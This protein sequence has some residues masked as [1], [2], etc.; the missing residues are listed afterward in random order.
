QFGSV[1]NIYKEIKKNG[2]KVKIKP[3][4]LKLLTEGKKDAEMS[5]M[6]ATIVCDVPLDFSIED[7]KLRA[8]DKQKVFELFKEL[9]FRSLLARLP[10]FKPDIKVEKNKIEEDEKQSVQTTLPQASQSKKDSKV[11]YKLVNSDSEFTGFIN[12]L[13][14][15]K[16]F[17]LDTESTSLDAIS[18]KLLGISFCWSDGWAY[19]LNI[20]DNRLWLKKLK[21]ILESS[22]VEKFGHNIKYDMTLLQQAGIKIMPVIFDSMV[23]SYLLNPGT[24][25]HSLDNLAFEVFGYQMQPITDLIGKGKKKI[26]MEAVP[27]DKASWYACEDAD[28]TYRLCQYLKPELEEKNILGLMEKI[29]MPLIPVLATLEQNGV[30]I[31]TGFLVA[32]SKQE[33]RRLDILE[34]KIYEH[35]KTEFNINS[36]LQLKEVLFE[37]LKI[38][39]EGISKIKTG[40][41]TAAAELEKLKNAHPIIPL[42]SDF[43]ELSKLRSTYLEALPRLVN[44]KTNRVHTSFNQTITA[45]G[46]LSSSNPNLQNIPIRTEEGRKIRQAFIA[47]KGFKIVAADYSQIELRIIASM[48]ND[49]KM[50]ASFKKDEDIH[51][52]TAADIHNIPIEEVTKDQRYEAKEVNFGILYG[53]GAWGLA[54]RQNM[55]RERARAFI[56]KYFYTHQE[57]QEYLSATITLAHEQGYVET[58]FGRRRYLSEINSSMPQVRAAA[59]RMAVNMPIQG[60]AADLL[61]IAMINILAKLPSFCPESKMILQVHD[62]LVFEVLDK[63]VTKMAKFI[64]EEMN[65]VYKLKV[66]IKTDV[67]VGNN[68]GALKEFKI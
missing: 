1:D 56:E 15:Q 33:K 18:A 24:R 61:K 10:E 23:G 13:E 49:E 39:T 40:I 57:I 27:L 44:P 25:G 35:A 5:K 20:K 41:S 65:G 26:S 67:A 58:L 3:R 55:S 64:A 66:P 29:E 16:V 62:E 36:P 2:D 50:I 30:K 11:D 31:D 52:R 17:A 48:A 8:Y 9:E 12:Q 43:R 60:T 22:Q 53:M 59:E 14:K 4:Y 28:Y 21:P 45:T 7:S 34:K 37:K 47:E 46:R 32:M 6:L 51:R 38:N 68:W 63:D 54:S 19:Y 42:L